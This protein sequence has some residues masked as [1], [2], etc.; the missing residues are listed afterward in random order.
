MRLNRTTASSYIGFWFGNITIEGVNSIVTFKSYATNNQVLLY[1]PLAT[2]TTTEITDSTL[3]SQLEAIKMSYDEQTNIT[4]TN[5]DLPFILDI[6]A[7]K[8]I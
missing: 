6:T 3:I 4:Q 7:L 2:P 1:Y 8:E 5:A